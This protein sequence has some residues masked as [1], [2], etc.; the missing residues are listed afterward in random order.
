[1]DKATQRADESK[2]FLVNG[3]NPEGRPE[4]CYEFGQFRLHPAELT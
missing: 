3:L 2:P 1:M 4:P